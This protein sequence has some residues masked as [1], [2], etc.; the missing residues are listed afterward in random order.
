MESKSKFMRDDSRVGEHVASGDSLENQGNIA[1]SGLQNH[2]HPSSVGCDQIKGECAAMEG[3][4]MPGLP[5]RVSCSKGSRGKRCGL[6]ELSPL[7]ADTG[8]TG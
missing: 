5:I 6:S 1:C 3:L 8:S 2:G 7:V 4:G